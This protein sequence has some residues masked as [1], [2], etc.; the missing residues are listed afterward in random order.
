M[1]DL[2]VMQTDC[3]Q[4]SAQLQAKPMAA[5]LNVSPVTLQRYARTGRIPARKLGR[6]WRFDAGAVLAALATKAGEVV[7]K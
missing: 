5:I 1:T 4:I 7:V 6:R 2:P 3:A